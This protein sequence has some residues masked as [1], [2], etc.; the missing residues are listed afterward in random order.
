MFGRKDKTILLQAQRIRQLEDILC[1]FGLHDWVKTGYHFEG[2]TGR[3]DAD[4]VN[5]F[6]C[7]RCLK[8]IQSRFMV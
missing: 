5:H 4:T 3:G 6:V 1:P 7:K 8:T 2:G